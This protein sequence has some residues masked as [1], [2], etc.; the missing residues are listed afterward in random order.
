MVDSDQS[1]ILELPPSSPIPVKDWKTPLKR[2]LALSAALGITV[3]IY[4]YR[5]AIG[6]FGVYG[7]P[8]VFGLSVLGNATLVFPA[9][10]FVVVFALSG[11]LNPFGLGLAAGCG[12]AIGEMTGYL[13]GVG[14][15]GVV[16]NK[17]LYQ[18]LMPPMQRW[19]AWLIFLMALVP[20]PA[21]DVG[22]ILS[23]ALKISWWKFLGAAAAGKSLRFILLALSGEY[24]L[25][26]I[27][28][29]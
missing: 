1:D 8:G 11:V 20:N 22:G 29:G 15:R 2:G 7:Y 6:D 17:Q 24:L 23:G 19:G 3:V 14:G 5:D 13:A 4:L 27:N 9:P 25:S 12:A 10:S 18:R 26:F 16:E 21:F 28:F